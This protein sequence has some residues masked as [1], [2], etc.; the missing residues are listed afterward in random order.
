[1]TDLEGTMLKNEQIVIVISSFPV[2]LFP[3][4]LFP[5]PAFITTPRTLQTA[6]VLERDRIVT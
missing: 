6:V 5:V 1:M 4:S 2:S 3:V